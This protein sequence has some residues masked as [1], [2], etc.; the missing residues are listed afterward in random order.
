ML[1]WR[2]FWHLFSNRMEREPGLSQVEKIGCLE[3][4][5]AS[6]EAR[7][8]ICHASFTGQYDDVVDALKGHY[9]KLKLMNKDYVSQLLSLSAIRDDHESLVLFKRKLTKHI[10]GIQACH[11]ASFEQFITALAET[12]TLSSS[13]HSTLQNTAHLHSSRPSSSSWIEG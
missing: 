7:E 1:E 11:G 3:S 13:G 5:M 9:D 10:G 6:T 8:I 4:S 2:V 12:L